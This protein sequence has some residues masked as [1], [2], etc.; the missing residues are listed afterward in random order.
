MWPLARVT[1]LTD[2]KKRTFWQAVRRSISHLHFLS[3]LVK[4]PFDQV[5]RLPSYAAFGLPTLAS[6]LN[7]N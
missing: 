3:H 7:M 5:V 2:L 6:W 4:R 1:A